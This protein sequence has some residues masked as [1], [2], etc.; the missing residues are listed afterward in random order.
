M[1]V[2]GSRITNLSRAVSKKLPNSFITN[3]Y[4]RDVPSTFYEVFMRTDIKNLR[5]IDSDS[6]KR[7]AFIDS[8]FPPNITA[9]G[10][11]RNRLIPI[12]IL[13]L[14]INVGDHLE[15]SDLDYI[16][17]ILTWIS[18][19]IYITPIL[20]FADE[21][22]REDRLKFY[23][24]FIKRLLMSKKSLPSNIRAGASVPTLYLPSKIPEVLKA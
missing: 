19:K 9:D 16:N 7:Q 17:D 8:R 15:D 12:I 18:N 21:I 20:R 24:D 10:T 23:N 22:I 14:D 11:Y 3:I 4:L 13:V 5:S 1:Q 2:E 6:N